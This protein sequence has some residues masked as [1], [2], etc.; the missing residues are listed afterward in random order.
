M[1]TKIIVAL[2]VGIA[3]VGLSGTASA[4]YYNLSA[5]YVYADSAVNAGPG[6][7][8]TADTTLY[9][10]VTG[11][12]PSGD[13]THMH[14]W[15]QNSM[16]VVSASSPK[17]DVNFGLVQGGE[18]HLTLKS[19]LPKNM[20]TFAASDRAFQEI[21]YVANGDA[22]DIA[23]VG[24]SMTHAS[25]HHGILPGAVALWDSNVVVSAANVNRDEDGNPLASIKSG[26]TGYVGE[27]HGEVLMEAEHV[28]GPVTA[29]SGITV[30]SNADGEIWDPNGVISNTVVGTQSVNVYWGPEQWP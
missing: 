5:N 27:A 21:S 18:T 2:V 16:L 11:H 29:G 3:L 4:A 10:E 14:S 15:I 28:L 20:N 23:F 13:A 1:N 9:T 30:W 17:T 12:N 25:T 22:F 24:G 7:V 19:N 6:G 26:R 8:F